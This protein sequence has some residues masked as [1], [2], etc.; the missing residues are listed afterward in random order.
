MLQN[1]QFLVHEIP[2]ITS[3][4]SLFDDDLCTGGKFRGKKRLTQLYTCII[5]TY[6]IIV[7][8]PF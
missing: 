5:R 1:R 3:Q 6:N 7:I 2:I 4:T 8:A